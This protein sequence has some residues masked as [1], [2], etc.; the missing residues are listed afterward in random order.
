[1]CIYCNAKHL[2]I[3]PSSPNP[4]MDPTVLIA[5]RFLDAP[6][7][8]PAGLFMAAGRFITPSQKIQG[9]TWTTGMLL[10]FSTAPTCPFLQTTSLLKPLSIPEVPF[11]CIYVFLVWLYMLNCFGI[12]GELFLFHVIARLHCFIGVC[13]CIAFFG[14]LIPRTVNHTRHSKLL[15]WIMYTAY[16]WSMLIL[17]YYFCF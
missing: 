5:G 11:C 13:R 16:T 15:K 2:W 7:P 6:A 3:Q 8:A 10:P 14:F 17:K 4:N 1:M 9:Q 12:S